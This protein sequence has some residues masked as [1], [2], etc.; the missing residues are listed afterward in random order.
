LWWI[1]LQNQRFEVRISRI[2]KWFGRRA[3]LPKIFWIGS[4][5]EKH[6]KL[7]RAKISRAAVSCTILGIILLVS[8]ACEK[9]ETTIPQQI[10][11]TWSTSDPPYEGRFMR[12]AVNQVSFGSSDTA[13]TNHR[14]VAVRSDRMDQ[15]TCFAIDYLSPDQ[16]IYTLNLKFYRGSDELR[17]ANRQAPVWTRGGLEKSG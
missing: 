7:S 13:P 10:L 14:V 1:P 3:I 17:L 12:L 8:S 9:P 5:P 4:G 2:R 11:G 6:M 16:E 15:I